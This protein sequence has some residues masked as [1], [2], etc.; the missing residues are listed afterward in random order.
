[1]HRNALTQTVAIRLPPLVAKKLERIANKKA[2]GISTAVREILMQ[3]FSEE[4]I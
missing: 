4:N 3:H 1:M 2:I